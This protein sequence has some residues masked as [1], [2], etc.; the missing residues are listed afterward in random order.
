[1]ES[2]K[3]KVLNAKNGTYHWNCTK[4][5]NYLL[6]KKQR[7]YFYKWHYILFCALQLIH[8]MNMTEFCYFF[9]VNFSTFSQFIW[10]CWA[11]IWYISFL[12]LPPPKGN[13]SAV[14]LVIVT[15]WGSIVKHREH[16]L[17]YNTIHPVSKWLQ[18]HHVFQNIPKVLWGQ[19]TMEY[20]FNQ[21]GSQW[22]WK[23]QHLG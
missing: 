21:S 20:L 5:H 17:V 12:T 1:M 10:T 16:A 19:I 3:T 11:H 4:H 22:L 14:K 7:L 23:H 6:Q 9:V 2:L 15:K 18:K 13:I 8:F